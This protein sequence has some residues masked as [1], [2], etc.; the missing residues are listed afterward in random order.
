MKDNSR[1][2]LAGLH[3]EQDPPVSAPR[4]H[5]GCV[6]RKLCKRDDFRVRK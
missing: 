2:L 6:L 3:D 5:V 4:E 1:Y